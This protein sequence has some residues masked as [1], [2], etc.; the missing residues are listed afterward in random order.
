QRETCIDFRPRRSEEAY[1]HFVGH[2]Q[3]CWSTVGRDARQ[4]QQWIS[5]G[6]GCEIFGI[7]AHEMGHALGVFHQQSR[8]DRDNHVTIMWSR[9][10]RSLEGNFAKAHKTDDFGLPYDH[11]S[12]MHYGPNSFSTNPQQP[13]M[14]AKDANYFL[15]MGN[16]EGPSFLDVAL[17]NKLY[18]C[19]NRCPSINCEN[20]GYPN[21]RRCSECK[22]S[23][24]FAGAN[25]EKPF[26]GAN[27]CGGLV[28][29][30]GDWQTFGKTANMNEN[31]VFH[32]NAPYGRSVQF[33]LEKVDGYC[34]YGCGEDRV[35]FRVD[36]QKTATGYRFCCPM[37]RD[38][39]F[40]SVSSSATVILKATKNSASV[41]FRYRAV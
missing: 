1:L 20:E 39:R 15:T 5:I 8:P 9:I 34:N 7:V 16:R 18:S 29:V 36:T 28:T 23:S 10:K 12:V 25:C 35:E 38:R 30:T 27:G 6:D 19:Q 3:G 11:G 31:C 13:T 41:R 22:C 40:T 21:P 37:D 4:K 32:F 33:E 2:D 14:S 17:V 26:Y 24:V